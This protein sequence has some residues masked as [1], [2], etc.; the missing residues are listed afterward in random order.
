MRCIA[1]AACG[2]GDG[3]SEEKSMQMRS[4]KDEARR[5]VN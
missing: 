4:R 3:G 2:V 5:R 1:A